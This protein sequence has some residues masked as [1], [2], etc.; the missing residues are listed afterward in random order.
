MSR[1]PGKVEARNTESVS[2]LLPLERRTNPQEG[3]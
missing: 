1:M 3:E 2:V